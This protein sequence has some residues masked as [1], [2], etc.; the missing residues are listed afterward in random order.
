MKTMIFMRKAL[1]EL[2]RSPQLFWVFLL[3]PSMMVLMY[4][5][6]FGQSSGIANYLTVLVDNQDDGE[7]GAGFVQAMRAAEFDGKAAFT[8]M[9]GLTPNQA[10]V[11]LNE[12]KAAMLIT[13]P[14]QF[15]TAII[16]NLSQPVQIEM[17]G[18][19]L[20]DTYAFAQSFLGEILQSY[21]DQITGW[22]QQL[23]V[24]LEFLPNTGTLNDFQ[25]GVPGLVV[26]GVLFGIITNALLLT[27]ERSDGT[28]KRIQLS[29]ATAAQFL[30][31]ITLAGLFLSLIQMSITFALAT[32][33]GFKPVGSLAL[34]IGIG[35]VAGLSATGAGFMAASFSKNEGEAAGYGTVLMVPLV[36]LSGAVF[37]MPYSEWFRVFGQPVQPYD[38]MPTTHAAR[39]MS[40][41]ILYGQGI[42]N[43]VYDLSMLVLLSAALLIAGIWLYHHNVLRKS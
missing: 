36:F 17:L 9:E 13:L 25:V 8:V 33:V 12:G 10:K 31:G 28:L 3:F 37:P 15:S 14:P 6:A 27:R 38:I 20:N 29:N 2:W 23:P 5:Y 1:L 18:D 30:G 41:V 7:L 35:I 19:P 4:Y 42:D 26:F 40:K 32:V 34:S 24:S 22:Q 16:E 21:A 43:M 39:A 11:L